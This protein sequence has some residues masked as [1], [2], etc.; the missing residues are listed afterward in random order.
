MK[1]RWPELTV[2]VLLVVGILATKHYKRNRTETM[3]S[4][5]HPTVLIVADL[6]EA[7]ETNDV[8]AEM[9]RTVREAGQRG[10]AVKELAPGAEPQLL[11]RYHILTAPT[12]LILDRNGNEAARFEGEEKTT[13]ASLRARLAI[14]QRG[15]R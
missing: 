13:L 3:V 2:V 15:K 11:K 10:I 7:G 12:V 4:S 8:C 5:E 6:S 9:I 14:L 1:V